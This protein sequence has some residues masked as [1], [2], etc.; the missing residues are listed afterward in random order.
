MARFEEAP[1]WHEKVH[2]FS[3]E[4]LSN[5]VQQVHEMADRIVPVDTGLLKSRLYSQVDVDG[6]SG[7]V[8]D[9]ADYAR[10]VEE[11]HRVAYR[12]A[13]GTIHYTGT[14]VPP[15]PYLRTSLNSARVEG[16]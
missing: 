11:G 13:D 9:D 12:G 14:V 15:Q 2:G 16:T 7:V 3:R 4:T 6:M 1:D 5:V 10:W 8:G